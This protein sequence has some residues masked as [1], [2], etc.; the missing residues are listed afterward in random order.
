M[1]AAYNQ[2]AGIGRYARSLAPRLLPLLSDHDVTIWS[3]RDHRAPS[4]SAEMTEAALGQHREYK[5]A[6]SRIDRQ[7][8]DRL[9][10]Y[11]RIPLSPWLRTGQ[12]DLLY[13]PDFSAPPVRARAR[14]VTIHDVAW[15]MRPEL[16]P[17][18][19]ARY[20]DRIVEREL[21]SGSLIVTV[22]RAAAQDIANVFDIDEDR[23]TIVPNGVD[24][25]FYSAQPLSAEARKVLGL[26]DQYLLMVG[27]IEPR[28]NH[29]TVLE[30]LTRRTDRLPFLPL[31]IVGSR[32]WEW[33]PV[34]QAMQPMIAS[35]S[36]IYLDYVD[37]DVL[38]SIYASAHATLYPSWYEGFGLP[39]LESLATGT[40]VVASAIPSGRE[41]AGD[42]ASY[43]D[44]SEP[45]SIAMAIERALGSDMQDDDQRL[46]RQARARAY[47]WNAS[48]RSLAR[49]VTDTG[50]VVS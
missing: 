7:T 48:A 25:R 30:A 20:L 6:T 12:Q 16:T 23:I 14:I 47:D 50:E 49:L 8:L 5:V 11:T 2:V 26:P 27:T 10:A 33:Q 42:F 3:A 15:R 22:S 46:R 36:V 43:C 31:V 32:G 13:S 9:Q 41:V 38:P 29:R 1:S 18:G 19:L 28:K 45:E 39:I 4:A 17:R 35:G 24:E 21:R 34:M 44:P 40:P 37:D